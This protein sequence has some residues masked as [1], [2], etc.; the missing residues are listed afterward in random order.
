MLVIAAFAVRFSFLCIELTLANGVASA[1]VG[2]CHV[3]DAVA[4][5]LRR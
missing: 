2:T 3:L 1:T 4:A 5:V